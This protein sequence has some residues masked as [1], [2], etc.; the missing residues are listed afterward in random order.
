MKYYDKG[1]SAGIEK[2][3]KTFSKVGRE[4][5]S[6]KIADIIIEAKNRWGKNYGYY[7]ESSKIPKTYLKL[8]HSLYELEKAIAKSLDRVFGMYPIL[9]PHEGPDLDAGKT[10]DDMTYGWGYKGEVAE[11]WG[12]AVKAWGEAMYAIYS[13]Y[14]EE[15]STTDLNAPILQLLSENQ[16][17]HFWDES[18]RFAIEID[19]VHQSYVMEANADGVEA[20]ASTMKDIPHDA[21][22]K[23]GEILGEIA[24]AGGGIAG[25]A[26]EGLFEGIT[27]AIGKPLF[28]AI[29]GGSGI[30]FYK[31]VMAGRVNLSPTK[32]P[33]KKV[34][35]Y[36]NVYIRDGAGSERVSK[37]KQS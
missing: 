29:L 11:R 25:K 13:P 32:V 17:S 18:L 19:N 22:K 34:I 9:L 10:A 31:L 30:I 14:L 23:L 7:S 37:K 5:R 16:A 35:R 28:F 20:I 4:V 21:L 1:A 15:G 12:T 2:K 27:K 3:Q 33:Q 8:S 6:S 24:K 26:A 36:E